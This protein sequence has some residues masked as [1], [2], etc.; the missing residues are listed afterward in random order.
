MS[1]DLSETAFERNIWRV[2]VFKIRLVIE[3]A[4]LRAKEN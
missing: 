2:C 3:I 1:L 4:G